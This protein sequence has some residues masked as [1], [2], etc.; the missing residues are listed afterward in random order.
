MLRYD[1][2]VKDLFNHL[3]YNG[4][5][6]DN[7]EAFLVGGAKLFLDYDMTYQENIDTI[8]KE[9]NTHQIE[10]VAED[11]GGLS[12]R[13]VIFD[14]INEVLYVKKSWEFEY[15]KIT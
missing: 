6:K 9:L 1:T 8:R 7:L 15:R 12:E 13:S 3:L 10:I 2:S 11:L 14:T 5:N 4:A